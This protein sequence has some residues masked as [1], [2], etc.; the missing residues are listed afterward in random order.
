MGES[1]VGLTADEF[2]KLKNQ[3]KFVWGKVKV[4]YTIN[5]FV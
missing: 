2:G 5:S 1:L 3:V 4:V